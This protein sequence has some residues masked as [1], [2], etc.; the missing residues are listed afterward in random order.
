MLHHLGVEG[1]SIDP[2]DATSALYYY[3]KLRIGTRLAWKYWFQVSIMFFGL[4]G[5]QYLAW[6][7][8][9]GLAHVLRLGW[10]EMSM[11]PMRRSRRTGERIHCLW[12]GTNI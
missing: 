12:N 4:G 11:L 3:A 9:L 1:K 2:R 6:R 10:H 5:I 8:L 7:F